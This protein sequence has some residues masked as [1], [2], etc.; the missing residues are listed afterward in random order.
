MLL[1]LFIFPSCQDN[2]DSPTLTPAFNK[3]QNQSE[4]IQK[5]KS[6]DGFIYAPQGRSVAVYGLDDDTDKV[7]LVIPAEI[8]GLPVTEIADEAFYNEKAIVSVELP[9]T[10]IRIGKWSF[11]ECEN[12]ISVNIPSSVKIIGNYAFTGTA[13]KKISIPKSVETMDYA[14]SSCKNLTTVTLEDGITVY[15]GFN[16]CTSLEKVKIP[17]SVKII[18]KSA[19]AG[20]D[21]ETIELPENLEIIEE[22]AFR[23]SKITKIELPATVK[24]IGNSAFTRTNLTSITLPDGVSYI[25]SS[26]FSDTKITSI[27]IPPTL[28]TL[29]LEIFNGMKIKSI[30]IPSTV[31]ILQEKLDYNLTELETITIACNIEENSYE[32]QYVNNIPFLLYGAPIQSEGESWASSYTGVNVIFE[33]TAKVVYGRFFSG[34]IKSLVLGKETT[35]SDFS[36][37]DSTIPLET[38]SVT[39]DEQSIV[40]CK[41][42][43]KEININADASISNTMIYANKIRINSDCTKT[44]DLKFLD[45]IQVYDFEAEIPEN[46]Q[47]VEL[48]I[49]EN[50]SALQGYF[51]GMLF[52]KIQIPNSLF[53]KLQIPN[54]LD[55][56][57]TFDHCVFNL[58][59]NFGKWAEHTFF[60]CCII[61]GD[62]TLEKDI[63]LNYRFMWAVKMNSLHIPHLKNCEEDFFEPHHDPDPVPRYYFIHDKVKN[64]YV[65]STLPK[66]IFGSNT[67]IEKI[68]FSSDVTFIDDENFEG[69]KDLKE[70]D[71]SN[72]TY[73]GQSAF[74]GCESLEKVI[75]GKNPTVIKAE[76]FRNCKKADFIFNGPFLFDVNEGF[77]GY[78]FEGCENLK[79]I[80]LSDKNYIPMGCFKNCKNL[81][82]VTFSSNTTTVC[83]ETFRGCV[84]ADFIFNG[85]IEFGNYKEWYQGAYHEVYPQYAFADCENLKEIDLSS[86]SFIPQYAFSNCKKL[87]KII[88][89][90]E[91]SY[92]MNN[93]FENCTNLKE[94]DLSNCNGFMNTINMLDIGHS[95]FENCIG[96]EK[97]IFPSI[98]T[99]IGEKSF[100]ACSNAEFTFNAPIAFSSIYDEKIKSKRL[101]DYCFDGCTKITSKPEIQGEEPEH[102]FVNTS[103]TN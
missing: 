71:L 50:V 18:G 94:M 46:T 56:Y 74:S 11:E 99:W 80:D 77:D 78:I 34:Y 84:K 31:K 83:H 48:I 76:A 69:T 95:A 44:T 53:D 8:N 101:V 66:R 20:I 96:L 65:E 64:L 28:E 29:N 58:D 21:S 19:F 52:D 43:T 89:S 67:S 100:K 86:S 60:W 70:I 32:S 38:F 57:L 54:Q 39:S 37:S 92:I 33:D 9:D 3:N 7:N 22:D 51:N 47:P 17:S 79:E 62:V 35:L 87:E 88:I 49:S 82:K 90:N 68:I 25:G 61:N 27:D 15:S 5:F 85:N 72:I 73:I 13:L 55:V 1:S 93:A 4:E 98:K 2:E 45:K 24:K 14:F 75:F 81:E 91:L 63:F 12:L 36:S 23:D 16:G 40:D 10:I 26:A 6:E 102:A 42:K 97:I 30:Y 103:I 41:I 59:F